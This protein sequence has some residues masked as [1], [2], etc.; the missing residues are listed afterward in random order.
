[1]DYFHL[2]ETRWN[3]VKKIV[4]LKNKFPDGRGLFSGPQD[5]FGRNSSRGFVF[6]EM[7]LWISILLTI[8]GGFVKIHKAYI[9]KHQKLREEFSREWKSI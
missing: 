8:T 4:L 6:L 3:T 9:K 7:L 1:M 5:Q 2:P